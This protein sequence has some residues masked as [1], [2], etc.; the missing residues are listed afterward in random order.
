[1]G[2]EGS[3]SCCACCLKP[4]TNLLQHT[5][6]IKG[7]QIISKGHGTPDHL[8]S[9]L[10]LVHAHGTATYLTKRVQDCHINPWSMLGPCSLLGIFSPGKL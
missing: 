4:R 8:A 7:F 1:M 6:G 5:F 3:G 9:Q 10:G 2:K